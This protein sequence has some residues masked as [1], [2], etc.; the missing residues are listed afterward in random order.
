MLKLAVPIVLILVVLVAWPFI[1]P[2]AE[3]WRR[4][5]ARRKRDDY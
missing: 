1:E 3:R 4:G 2:H 5:R